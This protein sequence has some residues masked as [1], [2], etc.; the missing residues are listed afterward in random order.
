MARHDGG[1]GDESTMMVGWLLEVSYKV[2]EQGPSIYEVREE[3]ITEGE[4]DV[5]WLGF[6]FMGKLDKNSLK[7]VN[8]ITLVYFFFKSLLN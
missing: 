1:C 6:F 5:I 8:Y 3:N 7:S 4:N 2:E